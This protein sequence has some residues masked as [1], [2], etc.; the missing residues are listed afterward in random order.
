MFCLRKAFRTILI[1]L[2]GCRGLQ[3]TKRI[4]SF[5]ILNTSSGTERINNPDSFA[6]ISSGWSETDCN[7]ETTKSIFSLKGS[8]IGCKSANRI[9]FSLKISASAPMISA[10]EQLTLYPFSRKATAKRNIY[11]S[12]RDIIWTFFMYSSLL[13]NYF[14]LKKYTDRLKQLFDNL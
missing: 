14:I 2:F 11:V 3:K 12:P 9:S 1:I 13:I 7:G 6:R 10:P 4:L 8:F 5:A